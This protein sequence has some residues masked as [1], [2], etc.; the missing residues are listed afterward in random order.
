MLAC[1]RCAL[2]KRAAEQPNQVLYMRSTQKHHQE[3]IL[4]WKGLE[5]KRPSRGGSDPSLCCGLLAL[6]RADSQCSSSGAIWSFGHLEKGL[7][8]V[9]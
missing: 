1:W 3:E 9:I 2:F 5:A 7:H 8:V 6:T 4:V